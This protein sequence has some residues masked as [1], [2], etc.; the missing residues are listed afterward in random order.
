MVAKYLHFVASNHWVAAMPSVDSG[1]EFSAGLGEQLQ[2]FGADAMS[3]LGNLLSGVTYT[4]THGC[5][6]IQINLPKPPGGRF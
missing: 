3:K 1:Q 5:G 6:K 4:N 2:S